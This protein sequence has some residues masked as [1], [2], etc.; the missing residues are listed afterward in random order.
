LEKPRALPKAL[1]KMGLGRAWLGFLG[2]GWARLWA[3]SLSLHITRS[4]Q[5]TFHV[6][7][8]DP[9]TTE[10]K[11]EYRDAEEGPSRARMQISSSSPK[12]RQIEGLLE[13]LKN[14]NRPEPERVGQPLIEQTKQGKSPF[15]TNESVP[16]TNKDL[17]ASFSVKGWNP[18][19]PRP[20]P[21]NPFHFPLSPTLPPLPPIPKSEMA[22]DV[23]QNLRSQVICHATSSRDRFYFYYLF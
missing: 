21:Y 4:R 20:K 19:E 10:S 5:G 1:L 11:L 16:D 23:L 3:L 7:D 8:S 13:E 9:E 18:F 22:T 6:P 14:L 12:P 2:P 15:E 17:S